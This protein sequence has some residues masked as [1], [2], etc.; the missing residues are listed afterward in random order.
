MQREQSSC[1][2]GQPASQQAAACTAQARTRV[3]SVA[4]ARPG[5]AG[6]PGA[7]PRARLADGRHHEAVHAV[8]GAVHLRAR[9]ARMGGRIGRSR[10]GLS[11]RVRLMRGEAAA[12]TAPAQSSLLRQARLRRRMRAGAQPDQGA[13]HVSACPSVP[14]PARAARLLLCK[15]RVDDVVDAVDG[16]R[17]LGDVGGDDDLAR[18]GRRRLKDTRL[19]CVCSGGLCVVVWC[20]VVW[21]CGGG[22]VSCRAAEHGL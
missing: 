13:A 16:E 7:L 15:S 11:A 12:P 4:L 9:T 19:G 5:A 17:R 8:F 1:A 20:D 21:W 14:L 3:Q 10:Y 2:T 22:G 18:A 6:A